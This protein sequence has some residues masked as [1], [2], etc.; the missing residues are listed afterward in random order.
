MGLQRMY[1][2]QYNLR[3]EEQRCKVNTT[4]FQDLLPS[5]SY[6]KTVILA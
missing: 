6:Q 1:D 3:K 4:L 2:S 5:N